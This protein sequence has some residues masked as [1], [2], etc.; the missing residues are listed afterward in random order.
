MLQLEKWGGEK[1]K[2]VEKSG[3]GNGLWCANKRLPIMWAYRKLKMTE[4]KDV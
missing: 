4:K 1:R 2:A 3:R